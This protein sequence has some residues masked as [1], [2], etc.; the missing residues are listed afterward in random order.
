MILFELID[1]KLVYELEFITVFDGNSKMKMSLK[2]ACEFG[3]RFDLEESV[4][5][6]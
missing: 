6:L 3:L 5:N 2:C 4:M 1:A